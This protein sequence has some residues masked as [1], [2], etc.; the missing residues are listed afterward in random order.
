MKSDQLANSLKSCPASKLGCVS[1]FV[2]IGSVELEQLMIQF[3]AKLD[4]TL[5]MFVSEQLVPREYAT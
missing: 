3:L 2:A 5:K 1:N 4:V